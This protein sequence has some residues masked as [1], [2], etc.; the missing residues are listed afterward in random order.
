M[1]LETTE[2]RG[3]KTAWL[4]R[5]NPRAPILLLLHGFP[6][7]PATWAAQVAHF[8][9]DFEVLCPYVRGA[10][11]SERARELS[12]YGLDGIGLDLLQL[13]LRIDPKGVRPVYC[14]G[15]DL[16]AVHAS[17]LA[18]HLGSRLRR[19][20]LLNGLPLGAMAAR[21]KLPEQHLKSWYIYLMQIPWLPEKAFS[22]CPKTLLRLARRK[23]ECQD[24]IPEEADWLVHPLNQYRALARELLGGHSR[25]VSRIQ[26]P[27]LVLWGSRDAFL[28]P[29]TEDELSPFVSCL[30]TRIVE[31]N[32]WLHREEPK[33]IN[34]LMEAFFDERVS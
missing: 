3:L 29:P 33:R 19:L 2:F 31:G 5:A 32:H 28:V 23:G 15:H 16:G 4:R 34:G 22:L 27:T 26:A 12:R 13:L 30:R 8:R 24:P 1:I 7:S 17:H 20:V 6:D 25:R 21:W 11:P 18:L 14:V 9:G 10:G